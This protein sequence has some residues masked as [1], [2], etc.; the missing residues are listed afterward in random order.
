[1]SYGALPFDIAAFA[2]GIVS[3]RRDWL[4]ATLPASGTAFAF[5]GTVVGLGANYC[6]FLPSVV[7]ATS[8][9]N[10]PE[11]AWTTIMHVRTSTRSS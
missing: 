8:P 4:R 3:R 6:N 11:G 2:A 9:P 5:V 10:L 1:M 7:E